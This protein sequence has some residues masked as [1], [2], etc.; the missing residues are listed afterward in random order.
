MYIASGSL[1]A[2]AEMQVYTLADSSK[3]NCDVHAVLFS[4]GTLAER[5]R[6]SGVD[7]H[8]IDETHNGFLAML[9]QANQLLSRLDVDVIHAHGYKENVMGCIIGLMHRVPCVRTIHGDDEFNFHFWELKQSLPDYFN[10]LSGRFLLKRIISV[11]TDLASKL[12]KRYPAN[13]I[14][15]IPNGLN[16]QQVESAADGPVQLPGLENS[17]KIAF[18]GR[19]VALKRVD[20]I[21]QSYALLYRDF[22][23]SY[24]LFII[25]DGEEK[26][27]LRTQAENLQIMAGVHFLGHRT[28]GHRIMR[29]MDCLIMASDH[30]G[31]PM[32]VL[33]A[34]AL[35][36]PVVSHA[37]GHIPRVLNEGRHGYLVYEQKAEAF[38]EAVT[39]CRQ[40]SDIELTERAYR[41][42][43]ENFSHEKNAEAHMALYCDVIDK[44]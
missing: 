21:L 4:E 8:I 11:S 33:E 42:V 44:H 24:E 6:A 29:A 3:A 5:L 32:T 17:F 22:G 37:V 25:G 38:A 15:V 35:K 28:D 18:V 27:A 36:L 19:L 39:R 1:W 9:K 40:E 10:L 14:T 34:V 31:L 26:P 16:L 7:V 43:Q 23:L 41:Y 2:G 12:Q 13:K 30:E 20:L